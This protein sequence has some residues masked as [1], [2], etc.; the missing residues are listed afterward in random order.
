MQSQAAGPGP[1]VAA[2]L[3][4]FIAALQSEYRI[5]RRNG[6]LRE[7][8]VAYL[9]GPGEDAARSAVESAVAHG[10]AGV[11]SWGIAG[12]LVADAVPGTVVLASRV[13]R[14]GGEAC[15][16]DP[17][18]IQRLRARLADV[19]PILAGDLATVSESVQTPEAKRRLAHDLGVVAVDMESA[20]IAA[21]ARRAGLPF[22]A[23]RVIADG[24]DDGLPV[25]V[26]KFVSAKGRVRLLRVLGS[27]G[28]GQ[29]SI[30]ELRSLGRRSATA[31]DVLGKIAHRLAEAP[32]RPP[33]TA[34]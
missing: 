25:D 28:S 31:H 4:A 15:E 12:G 10:A 22:V 19:C 29:V 20:A 21:G 2:G 8:A 33:E 30:R 26:D 5:V 11:V 17:D 24:L 7:F 13:V 14:A 16:S 34:T 32:V 27:L 9:S 1:G 6:R 18:W 3:V 23:I